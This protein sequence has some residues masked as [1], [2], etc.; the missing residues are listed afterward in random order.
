MSVEI[1]KIVILLYYVPLKT[2]MLSGDSRE[3]QCAGDSHGVS[4]SGTNT[5]STPRSSVSTTRSPLPA[6][7]TH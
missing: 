3:C 2:R 4:T 6:A 5:V 7:T 1:A